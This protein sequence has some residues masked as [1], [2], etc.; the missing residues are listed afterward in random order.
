M[1]F[2]RSCTTGKLLAVIMLVITGVPQIL[3]WALRR[4][5]WI[6]VSKT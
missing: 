3:A 2:S 6:T 5:K 1:A 4:K